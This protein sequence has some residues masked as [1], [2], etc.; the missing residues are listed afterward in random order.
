MLEFFTVQK[1]DLYTSY[2]NLQDIFY[3]VAIIFMT[4]CILLLIAIGVLLFYVKKKI[5]EIQH[6]IDEKV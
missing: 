3:I 5:T 4:L 2:M 6:F 1:F